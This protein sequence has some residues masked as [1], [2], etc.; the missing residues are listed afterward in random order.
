MNIEKQVC[1]LEQG[2][3][4]RLLGID[5]NNC[6]FVHVFNSA[7]GYEGIKE[8]TDIKSRHKLSSIYDMG[9]IKFYPALTVS[10]LL[11]ALPF[12]I[13]H[14]GN[15]YFMSFGHSHKGYR[16]IYETNKL[17]LIFNL[18][19][20]LDREKKALFGTFRSGKYACNVLAEYLRMLLDSNSGVLMPDDVNERLKNA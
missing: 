6:C 12:I 17:G 10:E 7:I 16:V 18:D 15:D 14:E 20:E 3:E 11:K 19:D 9:V 8:T 13:R 1:T 5:P 2:Q 4:L